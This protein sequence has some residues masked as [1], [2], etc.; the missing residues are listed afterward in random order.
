MTT[1]VNG[2]L[3]QDTNA[4][5]LIF[6]VPTIIETLSAGITLEPGDVIA[7]GTPV[8]VG[9]GFDP[10]R[11][12]LTGDVVVIAAPG[13]GQLR[14]TIGIPHPATRLQPSAS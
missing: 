3:R 1:H 2:E 5:Q 6:D 4:S 13:L 12:L 9:I 10:P 7:T 14:N 11:Y 8:G